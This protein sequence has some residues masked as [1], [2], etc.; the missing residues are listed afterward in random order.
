MNEQLEF[1]FDDE[2]LTVKVKPMSEL[3]TDWAYNKNIN[4]KSV[5]LSKLD[6]TDVQE[7]PVVN[8]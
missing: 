3:I 4:V 5:S 6:D 8:K 2:S 7:I 1:N